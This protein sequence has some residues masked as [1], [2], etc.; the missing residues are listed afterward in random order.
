M[1]RITWAKITAGI[2]LIYGVFLV[3]QAFVPVWPT[4]EV[5]NIAKLVGGIFLFLWAICFWKLK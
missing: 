2:G 5:H 4:E 3:I 1:R